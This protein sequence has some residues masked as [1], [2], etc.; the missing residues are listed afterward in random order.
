MHSLDN[1]LVLGLVWFFLNGDDLF[2]EDCLSDLFINSLFRDVLLN[3]VERI[4]IGD[5]D[6]RMSLS[7]RGLHANLNS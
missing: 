4:L 2:G 5:V 6:A 3:R 1:H 7:L